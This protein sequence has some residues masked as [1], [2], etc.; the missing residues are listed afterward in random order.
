[1]R[2]SSF[3]F[4]Y[5]DVLVLL[6]GTPIKS[7]M[8]ILNKKHS[9]VERARKRMKSE[10]LSIDQIKEIKTLVLTGYTVDQIAKQMNLKTSL[11]NLWFDRT[12]HHKYF[13]TDSIQLGHKDEPYFSPDEFSEEECWSMPSYSLEDLS[14]EELNLLNSPIENV[15]EEELIGNYREEPDKLT[16]EEE[17]FEQHAPPK[18]KK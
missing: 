1:M 4:T 13:G 16:P 17:Y 9:A 18:P 7:K 6:S 10:L 5:E 14:E 11:V 3:Y 2:T 8:I 15:A 12:V